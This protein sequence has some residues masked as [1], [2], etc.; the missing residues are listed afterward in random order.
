MYYFNTTVKFKPM[1]KTQVV[2]LT[3]GGFIAYN[4][5]VKGHSLS[6]VNFYPDKVQS[7]NI[8]SGTPYMVVGLLVQN[9]SNSKLVVN[10]VAGNVYANDT[11]IGN[12]ANFSPYA[13]NPNS[14]GMMYLS[15]RFSVL[16]IVNDIFDAFQNKNFTQ[17]MVFDGFAN[18]DNFQ[19]PI[20][21]TYKVGL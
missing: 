20:K 4:L 18:V 8:V 2:L 14:Q 16:G 13:I 11:L 19:V 17:N 6:T 12:A 9:T 21:I 1:T 7:V 3:A 10:S 5:F 15:I